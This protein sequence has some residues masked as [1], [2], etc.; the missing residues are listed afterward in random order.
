MDTST[1][2]T[3]LLKL[4]STIKSSLLKYM[5]KKNISRSELADKLGMSK[6]YV[7]NIFNRGG[8]ITLGTLVKLAAALNLEIEIQFKFRD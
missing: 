1:N 7:T 4:L 6:S 5:E 3:R 2:N 8:D